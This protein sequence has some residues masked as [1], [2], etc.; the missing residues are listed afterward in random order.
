MARREWL[1]GAALALG[2]AWKISPGASHPGPPAASAV[3]R[4]RMGRRPVRR[5]GAAVLDRLRVGGQPVPVWRRSARWAMDDP[6]GR[7][8]RVTISIAIPLTNPSTRSSITCFTQNPYTTPW[9]ALPPRVANGLTGLVS[10]VIVA[11]WLAAVLGLEPPNAPSR[12]GASPP[13]IAALP[14][15]QSG[16]AASPKPDVGSLRMS[17]LCL[18]CSGCSGNGKPSGDGSTLF[19]GCLCWRCSRFHSIRL[20]QVGTA[21]LVFSLF[22]FVYG[23]L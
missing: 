1:L 11:S 4:R 9:I 19:L 10:L 21:A 12:S 7:Q 23:Q 6:H 8:I 18:R 17:N 22:R 2:W 5:T 3:A 15:G 14:G 20:R 13:R 16:D